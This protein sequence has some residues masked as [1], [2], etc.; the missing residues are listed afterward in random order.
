MNDCIPLFVPSNLGETK[1]YIDITQNLG[2]GLCNSRIWERHDK[3]NGEYR[4]AGLS[5]DVWAADVESAQQKIV[6][7]SRDLEQ[8]STHPIQSDRIYFLPMFANI[9]YGIFVPP[10]RRCDR[11]VVR[12][13]RCPDKPEQPWKVKIIASNLVQVQEALFSH[14]KN[15]LRKQMQVLK[16]QNQE[17]HPN[18]RTASL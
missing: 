12:V 11:P 5:C 2:G 18:E 6:D 10:E 3:V 7:L 8:N 9:S 13:L 14:E 4:F 15:L 17:V 16:E 1:L